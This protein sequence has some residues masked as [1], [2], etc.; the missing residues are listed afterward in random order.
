MDG[1]M[2]IDDRGIQIRVLGPV[3]VMTKSG[4]ARLGGPKQR[5]LL[6]MLASRVGSL[7]RTT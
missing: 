6:A 5:A 4:V 7:Q 1:A 2:L 3:E